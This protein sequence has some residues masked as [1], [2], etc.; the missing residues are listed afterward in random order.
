MGLFGKLSGS[1]EIT[2]TP[3]SGLL[4]AALTMVGIDGDIDD[5]EVAIIRRLDGRKSTPD[6]EVALKAWKMKSAEECVELV[7]N[8]LNEKQQLITIAN[9][10]DIAM[11]DGML[12]GEEEILLEAY[13]DAFDIPISEIEK[14][15]NIISIKNDKSPFQ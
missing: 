10:V 13:V 2:L 9:L 3:Q 11:A 1:Q 7:A 4:V 6:W 5:D 14:I 15:V 12:A 8:T